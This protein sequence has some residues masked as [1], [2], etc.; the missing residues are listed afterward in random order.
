MLKYFYTILISFLYIG[1]TWADPDPLGKVD[2]SLID[3]FKN[4]SVSEYILL[5]KDRK[6]LKVNCH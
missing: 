3:K 6:V 5:L 2:R 1:V 4:S